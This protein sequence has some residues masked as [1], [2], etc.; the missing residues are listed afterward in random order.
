MRDLAAAAWALLATAAPQPPSDDNITLAVGMLDACFA[1]QLPDGRFP[2]T[3]DSNVSLDGNGVQFFALPMLRTIVHYGDRFGAETLA[4][5]RRNITM[6][7]VAVFEEGN[8]PGTEA[9]PYYTNIATMRLV[10]LHLC[11]QVL[12]NAT[13]RAQADAATA[14][15]TTLV[16]GAG[17]HE[18]SSP[19]Y[20]AVA[21]ANLVGGAASVSD[22]GVSAVLHRYALFIFAHSAAGYFAPARELA[23]A[24]SRDYDFIFG[25]A[26][27]DWAFALSGMAAAGGVADADDFVL[28]QDPI[29]EAELFVCYVRGDFP[30]LPADLLALAAP[31]RGA[32]AWRVMQASFLATPGTAR[33]VD[34]ADAYLFTSPAAT[35][36]VSSIYYGQQDKMVNA[37]LALA[38]GG[39]PPTASPRL[40]QITFV[41]DSFDAPYGA[42]KTP[43]GSGHAKPTHL[44]PTVAAVQDKGLALVLNDITMAIENTTHGGPF[45]SLAANVLLPAGGG[46]DAIYTQRGGRVRNISRAAP[47]VSLAIGET[48]A[49]RSAGGI[50]AFR[51]PFIDGLNGFVPTSAIKFDGPPGTDAA[52][53]VAYMY[54]GP[55]T[56]F[57]NNPP[58]SRSL[59]IIGVGA[60]GSDAEALEFVAG[61]SALA[62][63]DNPANASNWRVSVAPAPPGVWPRGAPPGFASTLEASMFVPLRKLILTREVNGSATHIPQGGALELRVSDGSTRSITSATFA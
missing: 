58:P 3:F 42:V 29:T 62:V 11:A 23:G 55:N 61:F 12:G 35:L 57:P 60:A 50:V 1:K 10:N 9:Q 45:D 26:G 24:H 28:D 38:T 37:Q 44:K 13:V 56:T 52:R 32:G 5:W 15:W 16:D 6:A 51:M 43:D 47:D 4:R 30:A 7:A 20:T 17:F 8:G 63:T 46:V 34:G 19:T 36:G 39:T 2:W 53:A 48:V 40:A 31:Q 22:A 25:S 59:L 49:V 41:Q 54:R 14:A 21:I 18:Y 27:M 33:V